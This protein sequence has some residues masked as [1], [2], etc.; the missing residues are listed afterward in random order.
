MTKIASQDFSE[1]IFANPEGDPS[2]WDYTD[3]RL[4]VEFLWRFYRGINATL[5]PQELQ[6]AREQLDRFISN[7]P[8][9]EYLSSVYYSKEEALGPLKRAL[10]PGEDSGVDPL[11]WLKYARGPLGNS[12]S[13][14]IN[15]IL[16]AY[17]LAQRMTKAIEGRFGPP[18]AIIIR[19]LQE[20]NKQLEWV[21]ELEQIEH[22]EYDKY[23][24]VRM[25]LDEAWAMAYSGFNKLAMPMI[26]HIESVLKEAGFGT[27]FFRLR[28][29]VGDQGW[30]KLSISP[31][32]RI[33][34]LN[35]IEDATMNYGINDILDFMASN[36]E[37][38]KQACQ[39]IMEP[40]IGPE[41]VDGILKAC[42]DRN[43]IY[44]SYAYC[45]DAF[46]RMR[47]DLEEFENL[48]DPNLWRR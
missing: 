34:A 33:K 41:E 4:I 2:E 16:E 23:L 32:D 35:S 36:M 24:F 48:N 18:N 44:I 13:E 47:Q 29:F 10:N 11:W 40:R 37:E 38:H 25:V 6:A 5:L 20:I 14:A 19:K 1:G 26:E 27:S 28:D 39:A 12:S 42:N 22:G 45:H 3:W 15:N 9:P 46:E 30:L 43:N 17:S 31:K 7:L 21:G 8:L